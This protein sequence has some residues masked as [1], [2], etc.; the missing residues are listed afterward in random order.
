MSVY[1]C[2][3]EM[4]F[5]AATPYPEKARG[6]T[7]Y[8]DEGEAIKL[9]DALNCGGFPELRVFRCL[10]ATDKKPVYSK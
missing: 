2:D 9:C 6:N 5:I 10:V 1:S 3:Y 4:F 7:F 8:S